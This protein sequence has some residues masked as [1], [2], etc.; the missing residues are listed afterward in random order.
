[1]HF[2]FTALA[3]FK[4]NANF[5]SEKLKCSHRQFNIIFPINHPDIQDLALLNTKI[6]IFLNTIK[7]L[8]TLYWCYMKWLERKNLRFRGLFSMAE[9]F[10]ISLLREMS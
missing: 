8:N 3:N 2:I 7:G 1:M 5:R 4:V 9:Y 10:Q 6:C